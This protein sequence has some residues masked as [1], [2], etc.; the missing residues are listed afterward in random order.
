MH[1]K[2]LIPQAE[3]ELELEKDKMAQKRQAP[4][5]IFNKGKRPRLALVAHPGHSNQLPQKQWSNDKLV[6]IIIQ[7]SIHFCS[8]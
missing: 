2:L 8:I 4:V 6:I 3:L 1:I 5:P 7:L